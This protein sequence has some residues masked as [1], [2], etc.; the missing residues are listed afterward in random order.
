VGIDDW[1]AGAATAIAVRA[2]VEYL[3]S[4]MAGQPTG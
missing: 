3:R 2:G 4:I 1:L